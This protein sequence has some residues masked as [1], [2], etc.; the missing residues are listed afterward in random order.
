MAFK[1]QSD[2]KR[3]IVDKVIE[4][5]KVNGVNLSDTE[6][7]NLSWSESDP[8]F[9]VDYEK[10]EALED[11]ISS[12]K[13]EAKVIGLIRHA[14]ERDIAEDPNAKSLYRE[15]YE[16]MSEGDHYIL[17]MMKNAIGSKLGLKRFKW[18]PF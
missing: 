9:K 17:I 11:E 13:Y 18:W 14:F 5:A 8:D 7:Y 6:R 2:A 3:F 1:T 10:A 16:K 12:D 15:A 4:Q